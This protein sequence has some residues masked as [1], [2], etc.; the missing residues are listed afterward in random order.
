MDRVESL[1]SLDDMLSSVRRLLQ[2]PGYRRRFFEALGTD[3]P[4]RVLRLL[5]AVERAVPAERGLGTIATA[6]VVDISTASRVAD[7]AERAALVRRERDPAD[8]RRAVLALTEPARALLER[9]DRVR[10]QLLDEVTAGWGTADLRDLA[11]ALQRL[12]GDLDALE[13]G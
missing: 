12:L 13:T 6:L 1:E 2:R 8:G 10:M 11:L 3:V 9:A 4:P 5:R 7:E